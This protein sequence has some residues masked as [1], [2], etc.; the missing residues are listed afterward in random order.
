MT[1]WLPFDLPVREDHKLHQIVTFRGHRHLTAPGADWSSDLAYCTWAP[2][3][4]S[5][6]NGLKPKL[7]DELE[8]F[9]RWRDSWETS[10]TGK[11]FVE[12]FKAVSTTSPIKRIV[13]FG[14]GDFATRHRPDDF[15][16]EGNL[17]NPDYQRNDA[18]SKDRMNFPDIAQHVAALTMA[19][20]LEQRFGRGVRVFAQDPGYSDTAETIL[21]QNGFTIVGRRGAAGFAMIDEETLVYSFYNLANTR[22]IVADIALPA[23]GR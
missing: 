15:D 7:Y 11:S 23:V 18:P 21:E 16:V 17:L 8:R 3:Y 22:E 2:G 20:L 12:A 5:L 13:C 9:R 19:K 10:L 1:D 6:W 14:L 4:I